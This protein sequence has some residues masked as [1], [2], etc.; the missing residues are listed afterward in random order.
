MY[1]VFLV[2]LWSFDQ[3]SLFPKRQFASSL[4]TKYFDIVASVQLHIEYMQ[5]SNAIV[6][7]RITAF[8]PGNLALVQ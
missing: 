1:V 7:I 2:T 3:H 4:V 5:I 6:T 8:S